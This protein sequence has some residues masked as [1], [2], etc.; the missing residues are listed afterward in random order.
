MCCSNIHLSDYR[1]VQL[2]A[3]ILRPRDL[4][5][6]R[7][8]SVLRSKLPLRFER[9]YN[10]VQ[11]GS[12]WYSVYLKIYLTLVSISWGSSRI[13]N[14]WGCL[15]TLIVFSFLLENSGVLMMFCGF[16]SKNCFDFISSIYNALQICSDKF[17]FP[18]FTSGIGNYN[19]F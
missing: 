17:Q 9:W 4:A 5:D 3:D 6:N 18:I 1:R 10:V 11:G 8:F 15:D 16:I 19:L 13:S 2:S 12:M 14:N 7:T